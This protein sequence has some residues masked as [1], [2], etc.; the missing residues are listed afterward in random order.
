MGSLSRFMPLAHS[1]RII[2]EPTTLKSAPISRKHSAVCIKV[3]D[4]AI[5]LQSLCGGS[6]IN[7]TQVVSVTKS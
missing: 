1:R 5:N 4:V 7:A 2:K 6:A 3:A